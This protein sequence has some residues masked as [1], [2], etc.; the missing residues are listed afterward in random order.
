MQQEDN[1]SVTHD[2]ASETT[3]APGGTSLPETLPVGAPPGDVIEAHERVPARLLDLLAETPTLPQLLHCVCDLAVDVVSQCE[4]AGAMALRDGAPVVLASSDERA[5][6]IGEAQYVNGEGPYLEAIHTDEPIQVGGLDD[7][8]ADA[9]WARIAR[10]AG[11]RSALAM[12]FTVEKEVVAVLN[13]YTGART[14]WSPA[15]VSVAKGLTVHAGGAIAVVHRLTAASDARHAG[16]H[17]AKA[18]SRR[19]AVR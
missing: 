18:I 9:V 4:S 8:S 12:P 13:L 19:V 17:R 16:G 10:D 1:V 6:R 5:W 15:A 7:A 11:I 3:S 2:S 14:D